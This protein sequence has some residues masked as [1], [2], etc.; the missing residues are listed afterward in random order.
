MTRGLKREVI[1]RGYNLLL[2]ASLGEHF[3]D[4]QCGFKVL[5][6]TVPLLSTEETVS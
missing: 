3:S 6:D 5:L 2:R 4:A 1:A